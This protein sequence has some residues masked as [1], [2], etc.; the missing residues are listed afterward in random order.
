MNTKIFAVPAAVLLL[1]GCAA[2]QVDKS[3]TAQTAESADPLTLTFFNIVGA[4][5]YRGDG[6]E[7]ENRVPG[8]GQ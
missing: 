7:P 4:E 1:A 3:G 5:N 8:A 2:Q 6:R